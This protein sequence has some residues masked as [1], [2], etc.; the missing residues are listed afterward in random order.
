ML[1]LGVCFVQLL[2]ALLLDA[3]E[4]S[5]VSRNVNYIRF[6]RKEG[7]E[8]KTKSSA[9]TYRNYTY[10]YREC[11]CTMEEKMSKYIVHITTGHVS[12]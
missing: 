3:G 4:F 11:H 12:T 6:L 5:W 7:Y 9:Y 2:F 8:C 10:H 1:V